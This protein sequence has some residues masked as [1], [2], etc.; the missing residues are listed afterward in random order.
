MF[1]T[2]RTDA[3]W[4][5]RNA[6][7]RGATFAVFL[8][9]HSRL[10]LP[11]RYSGRHRVKN[12]EKLRAVVQRS[13]VVVFAAVASAL[14]RGWVSSQSVRAATSGSVPVFRPCDAAGSGQGYFR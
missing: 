3:R 5:I 13:G 4:K 10:L 11:G 2:L 7:V 14:S 6:S 9:S 1:S 8:D 12:R